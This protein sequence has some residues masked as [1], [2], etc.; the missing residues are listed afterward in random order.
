MSKFEIVAQINWHYEVEAESKKA[1]EQ[2]LKAELE[3]DDWENDYYFGS[4]D[5]DHPPQIKEANNC[6]GNPNTDARFMI[7]TNLELAA[8]DL[9]RAH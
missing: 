8:G 5:I 3:R 2:L 6:Y 9:G 4:P 7:E 1:A